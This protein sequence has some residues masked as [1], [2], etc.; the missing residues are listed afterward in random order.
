LP[1][2]QW[3]V[4]ASENTEEAALAADGRVD[5]AWHAWGALERDLTRWWNPL[6]FSA[7]WQAFLARQPTRLEIALPEPVAVTALVARLGGSD[8]MAIPMIRVATSLD[9]TTWDP[10]PG[11]LAPM[12]DARVLVAD[13]PTAAHALVL[14][15]ARTIRFV[16]LECQGFDWYVREIQLHGA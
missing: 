2:G 7:R 13:A 3:T 15:A 16:R 6:P 10:V 1:S 14:P 4:T 9:G 12:P 5:T 8:P 11:F